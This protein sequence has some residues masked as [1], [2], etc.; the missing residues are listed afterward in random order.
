MNKYTPYPHDLTLDCRRTHRDRH[1]RRQLAGLALFLAT[2]LLSLSLGVM[3]ASLQSLPLALLAA[4]II[5]AGLKCA[6]HLTRH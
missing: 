6:H 4:L 5:L 3:L 2:A 1:L